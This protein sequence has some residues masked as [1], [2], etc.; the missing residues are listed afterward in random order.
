MA[1]MIVPKLM[2]GLGNQMFQIAAGYAAALRNNTMFAI[3]YEIPFN[4]GQGQQPSI[5]QKTFYQKIPYTSYIPLKTFQEPHWHYYPIPLKKELLIDGY[6]QSEKHFIDYQYIIRNL[7]L[8]PQ[9]IQDN[10]NNK[11]N[12]IEGTK[13]GIHIRR[14]DYKN[15]P[16]I[17]DILNKQYYIDAMSKF[18]DT[19]FLV[20]TDN[21]NDAI[22]DFQLENVIYSNCKNELEDLYLLTQCDN[23]ILSNSSFAW[24]GAYLG[25]I[26]TKVICPDKWF[27]IDGPKNYEDIY[28]KEWEK[29]NVIK[30]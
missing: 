12:K 17:H 10:I 29:I 18:N 24:W 2:G 13:T 5:Y 14:G 19:T 28:I 8:F 20:C 7:F 26:K 21:L 11:L 1:N 27:G 25:K 3:N 16:N 6:F 15:Y 22:N 9:Y 4:G 30:F 23:I